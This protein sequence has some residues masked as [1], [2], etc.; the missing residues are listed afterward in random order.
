MDISNDQFSGMLPTWMG[1]NSG[2]A[3]I[4]LSEKSF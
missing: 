4:D 1:N 3:A 2:L